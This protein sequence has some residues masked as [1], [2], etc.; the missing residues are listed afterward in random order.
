MCRVSLV[1]IS[2]NFDRYSCCNVLVQEVGFQPIHD[3]KIEVEGTLLCGYQSL[4]VVIR[5]LMVALDA[6]L[7]RICSEMGSKNFTQVDL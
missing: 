7:I 6:V 5:Q 4:Q 2:G 3:C 1:V